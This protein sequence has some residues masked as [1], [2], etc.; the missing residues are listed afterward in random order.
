M[1]Y[2]KRILL[3]ILCVFLLAGAFVFVLITFYKKE[4]AGMLTDILKTTYGLTLQVENVDVSLLSNWP[5]AS[6]ELKNISLASD[7]Y[8]DKNEPFLKAGSIILSFNLAKLLE[9]KF[10]VKSISIKNAE[11]ALI[12]DSLGNRNFAFKKQEV[13]V[14]KD[15]TARDLSFEVNRITIKNTHFRFINRG[16]KQVIAMRFV[17]NVIRTTPAQDG[18]KARLEG[19]VLIEQLLFNAKKGAFLKDTKVKLDLDISAFFQSKMIIVHPTSLLTIHNHPYRVNTFIHLMDTSWLMFHVETENAVY[20]EVAKFLPPNIQA[21]LKNFSVEKPFDIKTLIIAKLDI[22]EE[23]ILIVDIQ[24]KDNIIKIGDSKIPYSGI[25]FHGKVVSLDSSRQ[26]GSM[27]EARIQFTDIKGKIFDYPVTASVFLHNLTNPDIKINGR[28]FV[29]AQK[30]HFK[31]A[32]DFLLRG[33]CIAGIDYSGPV[34]KLNEKDF[35]KPIM[36]LNANLLFNNFSYREKDNPYIYVVN[37]KANVNNK[38]L[39]FEDLHLK[40][41]AGEAVLKGKAE[42]FVNYVLGY[43]NALKATLSARTDYLNLNS[44]LSKAPAQAVSTDK[45]TTADYKQTVQQGDNDQFEFNVSLFAKKLY[46]RKVEVENASIDLSYKNNL[47]TLK[48]VKAST[49]GGKIVAKGSI[50]DLTRVSADMDM[51]DID[52]NE[53]FIEFENFG[54]KKIES[55]NLKGRISLVANFKTDLDANMEVKGETMAGEVKLKLRDG[56]LENFEPVQSMSNFIWRNRNFN[57]VTFTEL[58]ETFRIRGYEM[59]I[60]ELEIASNILNMYVKGTYN[61]KDNSNI[62]ILIPWR[63]LQKRGKH[64]IPKSY[65]ESENVKGLKL[66]FSGPTAN[67]KLSLGHK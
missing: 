19:D 10:I 11:V 53:L 61:F 28:L 20:A 30:I 56:H 36:H 24:V 29:D 13:A 63:N 67:M 7:L 41:E 23:P 32:Q 3:G 50:Y 57:D 40:T 62:N 1:K 17:N 27:E 16:K 65:G 15:S 6:V 52:I 8:P 2:I 59:E 35:L 43:S 31:V 34:N 18:L 14:Q 42:G 26:R 66:N 54:Q 33:S 45:K 60:Q 25:S 49:C 5:Q 39:K 51:E 38:D 9:K 21:V 48:S 58:N 12:K 64:Y 47:L 37:G 44:F 4:M 46:I 22:R 55:K